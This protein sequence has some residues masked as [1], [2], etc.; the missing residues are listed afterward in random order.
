MAD[1]LFEISILWETVVFIVKLASSSG[2]DVIGDRW[3]SRPSV[4]ETSLAM[5]WRANLSLYLAAPV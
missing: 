5:I 1:L 3:F 4:N 2:L